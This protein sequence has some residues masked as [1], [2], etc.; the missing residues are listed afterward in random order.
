MG[1]RVQR[2]RPRR[3]GA[4]PLIEE[5]QI[6]GRRLSAIEGE[7]DAGCIGRGAKRVYAPRKDLIGTVSMGGGTRR[8]PRHD[9]T[10]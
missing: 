7:V 2:D 6:D 9:V 4:I 3:L 1:D 10:A 5:Q 8:F